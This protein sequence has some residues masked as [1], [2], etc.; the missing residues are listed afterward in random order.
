[1][2]YTYQI[3][4]R[5]FNFIQCYTINKTQ[6]KLLYLVFFGGL[7]RVYNSSTIE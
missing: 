4:L 1:M 3:Y 5:L 6:S 2:G 7:F